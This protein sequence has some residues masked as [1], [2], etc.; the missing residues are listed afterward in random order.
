MSNEKPE[1]RGSSP[2]GLTPGIE[3]AGEGATSGYATQGELDANLAEGWK[4]KYLHL[5]ADL[6]NTKKRLTR[7]SRQE[8][9]AEKEKLIR[10]VLPVAD[11]LDLALLHAASDEADRNLLQGIELIRNLLIKFFVKHDVK[12]I[13][14]WGKPFDP[15]LHEA[16][17][18]V[19]NPRVAP[20]TVV[21]VEQKG[22]LYQ[23]KLLR[24]AQVVV[25]SNESDHF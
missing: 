7:T 23:D 25:A 2:E 19:H 8:L 9:E 20:N 3:P 18:M 16:L 5:L 4:Y 21:R 10:D 13:E 22:Y 17:G 24:P 1:G 12:P 11:G 6:E 15:K 14:A